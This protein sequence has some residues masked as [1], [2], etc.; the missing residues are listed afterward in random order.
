MSQ[1]PEPPPPPPP[2]APP[3]TSPTTQGMAPTAKWIIGGLVGLV[4]LGGIA[5]AAVNA[6]FSAA[7]DDAVKVAPADAVLYG[8]VFLEPSN[9]QKIAIGELLEK[10]PDAGTP[11]EA[12]E[13]I[14][15]LLDE[16]FSGAG[17]TYTDDV[18]PWLGKQIAFFFTSFGPA[19]PAG[20]ALIHTED[21]DATEEMIAKLQEAD[22]DVELVEE[23]S[24]E[25]V[26]YNLY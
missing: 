3:P 5:Y 2:T 25:G 23:K 16:A 21:Q 13:L 26:D 8:N 17:I 24:Y 7:E 6:L 4:V 20:A 9:G 18:E 15:R 1:T 11:D 22:D 12:K 10:F 14:E 19:E